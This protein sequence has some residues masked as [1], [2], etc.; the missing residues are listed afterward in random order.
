MVGCDLVALAETPLTLDHRIGCIDA[1]DDDGHA[2]AAG[3]YDIEAAAGKG[4]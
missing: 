1:V 4:R 3:N 2:G